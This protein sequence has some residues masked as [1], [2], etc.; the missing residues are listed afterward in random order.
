M[1]RSLLSREKYNN[2]YYKKAY[3]T[4]H[5]FC[6][7]QSIPLYHVVKIV[8]LIPLPRKTL[9]EMPCDFDKI[10]AQVVGFYNL[11]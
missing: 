1:H 8:K 4:V 6:N 10:N 5:V 7:N 2:Y 9:Q 11:I 3:C